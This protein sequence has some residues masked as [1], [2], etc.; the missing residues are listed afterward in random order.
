MSVGRCAHVPGNICGVVAIPSPGRWFDFKV[1]LKCECDLRRGGPTAVR[2]CGFLQAGIK[3][4]RSPHG[5]GREAVAHPNKGHSAHLTIIVDVTFPPRKAAINRRCLV[6]A[7]QR[8]AGHPGAAH[9]PAT[10]VADYPGV[11]QWNKQNHCG[12]E[13][14]VGLVARDSPLTTVPGNKPMS[15][16]FFLGRSAIA[17]AR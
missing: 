1:F 4:I 6:K 12:L 7:R 8:L 15:Q 3:E 2:V 17:T 14:G 5:R 16:V 9:A 11:P 10:S 13:P